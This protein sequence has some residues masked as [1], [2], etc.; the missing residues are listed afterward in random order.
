MAL[1][2][3]PPWIQGEFAHKLE[4]VSRKELAARAEALSERYR[5]KGGSEI[6]RSAQDALAY[7]M[8]RMP[9]TYAAVRHAVEQTAQAHPGFAPTSLLDI[10]S[11]PGT[12]AWAA[13]ETWTS[14]HS[15]VL[16]DQNTHLLEMARTL[17]A[18]SPDAPATDVVH[19][20]IPEALGKRTAA[21]LVVASYALT[22][23]TA[24]SL[25]GVLEKL[26]Q[27]TGE[28]LLIVEPGTTDGFKRL[29]QCRDFL[30][31]AKRYS[32]CALHPCGPLSAGDGRA[33]VPLQSA[34]APHA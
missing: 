10:G 28:V 17:A 19:G 27:L 8:V 4:G 30:L 25:N 24:Q 15:L 34:I 11:G 20:S 32:A 31:A 5:S 13:L 3:L 2:S 21:D 18:A 26:W 22:E 9:A 14:L 7:A 16:L 12:A 33:L 1:I 6:I 23:L 29:L